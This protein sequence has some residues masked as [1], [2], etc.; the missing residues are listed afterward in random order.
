LDEI[1]TEEKPLSRVYL[2][3]PWESEEVG[4]LN[5]AQVLQSGLYVEDEHREK[6]MALA[7]DIFTGEREKK[8]GLI[9]H[10]TPGNGKTWVARWLACNYKVPLYICL[11]N[12]DMD[13]FAIVRMFSKIRGPAIVLMEDFDSYFDKKECKIKEAKFTFD[14]ILNVL[15]GVFAAPKRTLFVLTANEINKVSDT[16][17]ERPSRFRE[18]LEIGYPSKALL[19]IVLGDDAD[20]LMGDALGG[21]LDQALHLR[22][23]KSRLMEKE[24]PVSLVSS[25]SDEPPV[26]AGTAD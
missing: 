5:H 8:A 16:L 7:D 4:S 24:P 21:S 23:A 1:V 11:F 6:I 13:N 19:E 15:D 22:E 12:A 26:M 20:S 17:K 25:S 2:L 9:L 3:Q 10:G 18:V 14:T